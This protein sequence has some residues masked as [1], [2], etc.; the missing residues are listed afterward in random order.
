[1]SDCASFDSGSVC[2]HTCPGPV[3]LARKTPSPPKNVLDALDAVELERDA[4]VEHPDV[5]GV[6]PDR[7]PRRELVLDDLAVELDPGVAGA[8][9]LLED[10]AGAAEE[11]GADLLLEPDRQLDARH[12]AQV[13]GAVDHVLVAVGDVDRQDLARHL[14]REHDHPRRAG[15]GVLGHEEAAAPDP[16]FTAPK[17][18]LAPPCPT[19]QC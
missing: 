3:S 12:A 13:A 1:M 19:P 4:G 6:D 17:M 2:S 10:E 18:P 5:A 11:T 16:R 15:S 14:R 9:H 7:L 8:R